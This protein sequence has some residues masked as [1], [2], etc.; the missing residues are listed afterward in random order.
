MEDILEIENGV[1][2]RCIKRSATSVTI[3]DCVTEIGERAFKWCE[4][5]EYI[6]FGG[7]V[8]Q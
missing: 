3:P 6:E 8:A 1:L 5:L 2:I 4:S 7:I